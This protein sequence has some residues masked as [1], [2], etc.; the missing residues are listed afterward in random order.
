MLYKIA[1]SLALHLM[2][3][4]SLIAVEKNR[5]YTYPEE[6]SSI[7]FSVGANPLE[8]GILID[9]INIVNV[10]SCN[11]NGSAEVTEITLNGIL[12][13]IS[14]FEITWYYFDDYAFSTGPTVEFLEAK[15]YFVSARHI[16]SGLESGKFEFHIQDVIIHP[17]VNLVIRSPNTSCDPLNPTGTI[18][19]FIQGVTD[20]QNYEFT[21]YEGPLRDPSHML[22][23]H[24]RTID[25]LP[26]GIYT[27]EVVDYF[28]DCSTPLSINLP[29]EII[30]PQMNVEVENSTSCNGNGAFEITSIIESGVV[31]E[32]SD[33]EFNLYNSDNEPI[34]GGSSLFTQ[35]SAGTY[36]ISATN[37]LTQCISELVEVSI[38]NDLER[39]SPDFIV[40]GPNADFS[41]CGS[42]AMTLEAQDG[43]HFRWYDAALEGELLHEGPAYTIEN[44][45]ESQTVWI[46]AYDPVCDLESDRKE[47]LLKVVSLPLI[48]SLVSNV[49]QA[50]LTASVN[51]IVKWYLNEEVIEGKTE[52]TIIAHEDGIYSIEVTNGECKETKAIAFNG[53]TFS[54]SENLLTA[55]NLPNST[56]QWSLNGAVVE[57][58]IS[59]TLQ[60]SQNG[61][62]SVKILYENEA[63]G[64]NET[65]ALDY[66]LEVTTLEVINSVESIF[67]DQ[68]IKVYPIPFT[69]TISID[70]LPDMGKS[71]TLRLW[72]MNG[73]IIMDKEIK[74]MNGNSI[75]L[76]VPDMNKGIYILQGSYP[77]GAFIRMIIK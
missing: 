65:Q 45:Q 36:Y 68:N 8:T 59:H 41:R 56:Y 39:P 16:E 20:Y 38:I 13:D 12:E 28:T 66:T 57:Q 47:L 77:R 76:D 29:N 35:L 23:L 37:L 2:L 54:E 10:T 75:T 31:E 3:F 15:Q 19:V 58:G 40:T 70:L 73:K 72:D 4:N 61:V 18:E 51:G 60:I 34:G 64:L 48:T 52:S 21:W 50:T 67:E 74:S 6:D 24:T 5:L 53:L 33:Y 26:A 49:E 25:Q 7:S 9:N 27:V 14:D 42:G 69:T 63:G 71:L 62:Y 46:S 1:L 44:L 43:E 32:L 11:P 17:D 22:S 55:P 30:F